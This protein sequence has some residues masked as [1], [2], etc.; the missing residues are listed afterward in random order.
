MQRARRSLSLT[1]YLNQEFDRMVAIGF[2]QEK[3]DL[4]LSDIR[5]G[6]ILAIYEAREISANA[7]KTEKHSKVIKKLEEWGN[8]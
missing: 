1:D 7:N 5:R 6:A 8:R 3:I 2:S 4:C